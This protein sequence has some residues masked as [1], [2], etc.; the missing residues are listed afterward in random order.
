MHSCLGRTMLSR[1][2]DSSSSSSSSS[3]TVSFD[4][5]D[6]EDDDTEEKRPVKTRQEIAEEEEGWLKKDI[7]KLRNPKWNSV[8][9]LKRR[10]IGC[11]LNY[12]TQKVST[13]LLFITGLER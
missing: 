4:D 8:R 11:Q 12:F 9:E 5:E 3:S 6:D 2:L 1:G 10:Q 13:S 7:Q